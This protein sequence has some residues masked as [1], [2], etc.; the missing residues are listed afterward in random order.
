MKLVYILGILLPFISEIRGQD[1]LASFGL[2][3][4][5]YGMFV[6]GFSSGG[7]MAQQLYMTYSEL[8]RGKLELQ[9]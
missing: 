1:S 7:Y 8:F 2:E 6:A 4:D 5:R 9:N 3:V